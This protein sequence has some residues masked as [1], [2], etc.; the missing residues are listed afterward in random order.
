MPTSYACGL[1]LPVVCLLST[2]RILL[3][4]LVRDSNT[5]GVLHLRR[6]VT[7][8]LVETQ[9]PVEVFLNPAQHRYVEEL[10]ESEVASRQ[11]LVMVSVSV[12]QSMRP[13]LPEPVQPQRR[14]RCTQSVRQ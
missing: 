12:D 5:A 9:T 2:D 6:Q 1:G 11:S 14:S 13:V 3:N 10:Q 4:P 8:Q 7:L